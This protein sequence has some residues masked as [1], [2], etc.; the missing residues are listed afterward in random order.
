MTPVELA[1]RLN[2]A[3]AVARDAGRLAQRFLMAPASLDIKL[4]GPQDVLTAADGAV[5]RLIVETLRAAFPHDGFLGEE[6]GRQGAGAVDGC[7]WV[8]D[9]IDGTANFARA[10]PHWCVSIALVVGERTE[11]GVIYDPSADLLYAAARGAGAR[12]NDVLLRV[13][14]TTDVR[15]ATVDI[16]Y[17][18]RTPVEPFGRLVSRLLQKGVNVLQGGSAALGLARVADG[19]LDGYAERHLYAWDVLAGLLL[20]QE[21]GGLVN[22]FMARDALIAG[23]ETIAATPALYAVLVESMADD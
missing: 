16:G 6:G 2:A 22:D 1:D 5:E 17:S 18:S 14:V 12:C 7:C 10:L 4:K 15:R 19:R 11:V 23:N 8:I 13:S 21:A 3:K 20:V 9:P